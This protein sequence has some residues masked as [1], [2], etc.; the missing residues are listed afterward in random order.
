MSA[1]ASTPISPTA[2]G[3]LLQPP[4]GWTEVPLSSVADVCFSGVDKVSRP[5]EDPVRLCNYVDVYKNEYITPDLEFMRATATTSEIDR[6]RLELGDVIITKDS[7]TP[8]DIGVPAI[9]DY[10]APDLVCGYHLALIRPNKDE[11]DP[12]FLGKQLAHHRHARRFGRLANGLTRYGLPTSAVSNAPVW[13]PK[14]LSE[15]QEIGRILRLA[16]EAIARTESVIAKLRYVRAG[17]V[18][19][20]LTCGLDKRG[21]LRDPVVHP[22]QFQDSP[23][24]WIPR[25]WKIRR[26]DELAVVERGKFAH[27]PRNEPRFY[28]GIHP[29][30]Q[31][32]DIANAGG[33]FL[34]T[35]SQTLNNEGAAIS[36]EFPANTIAITIA[37]NIADTAILGRPMYLTDSVVGAVVQA[38]N[39]VRYI[40]LCIR[41]AKPR[42]EARAPQTAQ[43]N[44]N[45]QDLR[46]LAIA[47]PSDSEEQHRISRIYEVHT[48]SLR[49]EEDN[50]T[51]L[52]SLKSGLM[53]D[54]LTGRVP[55]PEA[56][57]GIK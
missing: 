53:T 34:T 9:V 39:S 29:F 21:E 1:D 27:R 32:G 5:S 15:Q 16:D 14:L 30:V 20:F 45:L 24:G 23:L 4:R 38:P 35:F 26:L 28:G 50:L 11:V 8:D 55:V 49:G 22:E 56:P 57:K 46:P 51:K 18:H 43:M 48:T 47:V 54:L 41:R 10:V 36:R 37:A 25:E 52:H 40:E 44:I 31:T 3:E 17:L 42:L 2:G 33:E 12:T 6:F 13:R 7:E 19:D